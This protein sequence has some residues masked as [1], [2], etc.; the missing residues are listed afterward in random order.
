GLAFGRR[1]TAALDQP[2]IHTGL[3]L[4][5]C[6]DQPVLLFAP[7]LEFPAKDGRVELDGALGVLGM[8]L[9]M[10]DS[11]H[12]APHEVGTIASLANKPLS[13]DRARTIYPWPKPAAP[14]NPLH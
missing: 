9:K 7:F 13:N 5:A 6:H 1:R 4:P 8:N 12:D 11:R 10:D 3:I 2:A 14:S